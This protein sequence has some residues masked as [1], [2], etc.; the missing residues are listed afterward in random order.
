MCLTEFLFRSFSFAKKNGNCK[1]SKLFLFGH[2][3]V[4]FQPDLNRSENTGKPKK[5]STWKQKKA[6]EIDILDSDR[7]VIKIFECI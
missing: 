5:A 3:S 6:C 7:K 1:K 4:P 2:S